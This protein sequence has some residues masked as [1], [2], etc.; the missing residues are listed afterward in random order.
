MIDLLLIGVIVS[1]FAL[2]IAYTI[3][4]YKKTLKTFGVES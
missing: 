1:P 2:L 4:A 3:Y